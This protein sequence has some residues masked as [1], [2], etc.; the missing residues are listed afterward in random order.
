MHSLNYCPYW[1]KTVGINLAYDFTGTV[2]YKF[3]YA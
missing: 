3:A 1:F 2:T